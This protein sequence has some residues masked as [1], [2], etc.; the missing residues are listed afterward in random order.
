[1]KEQG[2]QAY[3]HALPAGWEQMEY[4]DFLDARRKGIAKVISDGFQRLTHGETIVA[5][6]DT[7]ESRISAE[8][9]GDQESLQGSQISIISN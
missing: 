6:E 3:W 8:R 4:Q 5:G 7:F 9:S 2:D 1:V